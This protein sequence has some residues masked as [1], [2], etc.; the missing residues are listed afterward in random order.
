[1]LFFSLLFLISFVQSFVSFLDILFSPS[2]LT[3]IFFFLQQNFFLLFLSFAV[4]LFYFFVSCFQEAFTNELNKEKWVTFYSY[5]LTPHLFLFYFFIVVFM[6]FCES[7]L[8][9][10]L[11]FLSKWKCIR[12]ILFLLS[13]FSSYVLPLSHHPV[14]Y[15]FL[16][17]YSLFICLLYLL[18]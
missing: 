16:L 9:I 18:L 17:I 4:L 10:Y 2:F 7:L 13:V 15:L 8:F 3:T 5:F 1:M 6:A 11:P 14:A 12:F